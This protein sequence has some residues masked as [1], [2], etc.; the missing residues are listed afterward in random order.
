MFECS[1]CQ[2]EVNVLK[3]QQLVLLHS[4]ALPIHVKYNVRDARVEKGQTPDLGVRHSW[5]TRGIKS[6]II[7]TYL[8]VKKAIIIYNKCG[9][10]PLP[11][12]I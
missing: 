3:C 7:M 1:A 11:N 4:K 9:C 12:I 10:V 6:F 8:C 5:T 2:R